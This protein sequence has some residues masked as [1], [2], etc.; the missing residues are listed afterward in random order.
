M[1]VIY[2]FKISGLLKTLCLFLSNMGKHISLF[3][4]LLYMLNTRLL[5]RY[6]IGTAVII[7]IVSTL[8]LFSWKIIQ[9]AMQKLSLYEY[10][11][12]ALSNTLLISFF[13]L[14]RIWFS[15][16]YELLNVQSLGTPSVFQK[17][18]SLINFYLEH[19]FVVFIEFFIEL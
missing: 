15:Y 13:K 5:F 14:C 9:A 4:L 12:A 18:K 3:Y 6:S 17:H 7:S 1:I 8:Q 2:S 16:I 11:K 10:L 19:S